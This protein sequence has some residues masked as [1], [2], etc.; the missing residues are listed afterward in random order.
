MIE[1]VTLFLTGE[2]EVLYFAK[3]AIQYPNNLTL[4]I[5]TAITSNA[6]HNLHIAKPDWVVNSSQICYQM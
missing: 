4:N 5:R 6:G 3:K 2:S 1:S